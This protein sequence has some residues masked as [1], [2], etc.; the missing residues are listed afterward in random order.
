MRDSAALLDAIIGP[1][2]GAAYQAAGPPM[3]FTEAITRP[4]GT[5]RIGYSSSSAINAPPDPGAV[6]AVESAAALLAD[7]GHQ[8]EQ[9]SPPHDD[10]ALAQDFLDLDPT[11]SRQSSGAA[12]TDRR[13]QGTAKRE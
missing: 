13:R 4:P 10:E 8:V 5:L 3:P 9:V 2:H 1:D 7:L 11:L 12:S 6:A